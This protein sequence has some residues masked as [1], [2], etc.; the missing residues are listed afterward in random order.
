[1]IRMMKAI[2]KVAGKATKTLV[3]PIVLSCVDAI[4]YMAMF[5][6]MISTIIDLVNNNFTWEKLTLYSILLL[7]LFVVRAVIYS[8]NYTQTQYR[9]ADI[10]A[11]L[12]LS[13]GNHIRS[14]NLG[15]FNKNSIGRLS[16]TL[17]TDI[18]DFEQ[19][20][21]HSLASF[22][23]VLFFSILAMIFAFT[24]NLPFAAIILA[25]VLLA[26]P[27]MRLAGKMAG[28]FGARQRSSVNR[29]ISRTVEYINGI[30][31]FKLYNL[32]GEKFKRLDDSFVQLRRDSMKLELSIMPFSISFSIVT[33]MVIPIALIAG[34]LLLQNGT[35]GTQS[36]VAVI[37]ISIS[38]SN[39]MAT[40]GSLYPEM[41][42][43]N[44]AAE[45]IISV[46]DETPLPFSRENMALKKG[47]V[48]FEN[49]SFRYT[50]KVEV[51]HNINFTA[52][53][54][55]TTALIGPSGSG[56]TTVISL[57]SRFWDVTSGSIKIDG[58]DIRSISPDGLTDNM[59]V[60]FQDVY[61][62]NDTVAAN[63]RI[64]KPKATMEEVQQAAKA[65]QCHSFISAMPQGYDTMVGEG[66]STL[67]GGEKQRISIARAFLKDASIVL[68]DEST[69]SLDADNEQEINKALDRLMQ[70]K[71]V[72]VIAHRL[73][74]IVKADTILV[75]DHG[76]ISEQGNHQQL[77]KQGG[78]YAKM[79]EEQ[80]KARQ[81]TV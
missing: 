67:S 74:T 55:S 32:T 10:T 53:P 50:D 69:S 15:Y 68:L 17:T 16:S 46:Q 79:I 58:T 5:G 39:M 42:Y 75:L 29:V 76:A 25:V 36:F 27:L 1:M 45:N 38:I 80:S 37:M 73:N 43:L 33:S 59:A 26:F 44:K 2:G 65:A 77:L 28:K 20:L 56:K 49:V 72:I 64:G 9:G 62:L 70:N 19:V 12:R 51:L 11:G 6:T 21:T 4:L 52:K 8:I 35:L 18:A 57:I 3:L 30:K 22:F 66:G 41:N 40:L 48:S 71:T 14:L 24:V 81:W 7:G 61:L 78:W 63:I 23:K 34:T 47:S 54:G 60:V 31:T 13:L